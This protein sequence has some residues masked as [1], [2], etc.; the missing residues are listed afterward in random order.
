MMVSI[1]TT[2]AHTPKYAAWMASRRELR[3]TAG[4]R[5]ASL[6]E[7]VDAVGDGKRLDD[8]LLDDDQAGPLGLDR[9]QLRV[10]VADDDRRE[11]K[12]DLVAEEDARIGH[13]RPADGAHLLLAAG[14]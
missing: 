2:I 14:Q 3:R 9:R 10:D 8:V 4:E 6:L 11:A 5:H 12:A 13:Q 1:Q 7:A